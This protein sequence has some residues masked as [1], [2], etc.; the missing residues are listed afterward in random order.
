MDW[1]GGEDSWLDVSA[2]NQKK[3]WANTYWNVRQVIDAQGR[4]RVAGKPHS[5]MFYEKD[6]Q[7]NFRVGAKILPSSKTSSPR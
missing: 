1:I 7:L 5:G 3:L 2:Q 6:R 4:R